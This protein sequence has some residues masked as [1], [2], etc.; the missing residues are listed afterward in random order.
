MPNTPCGMDLEHLPE[1]VVRD[2]CTSTRTASRPV[3][4]PRRREAIEVRSKIFASLVSVRLNDEQMRHLDFLLR[5]QN[6][7]LSEVIRDLIDGAPWMIMTHL[8]YSA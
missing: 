1:W 8:S 3:C 6:K 7:S 2:Y 5:A 4:S